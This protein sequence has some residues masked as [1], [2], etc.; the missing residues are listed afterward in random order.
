M[1]PT[2][3]RKRARLDPL[4]APKPDLKCQGA[5]DS[6]QNDSIFDTLAKHST[7]LAVKPSRPWPRNGSF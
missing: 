2:M 5:S 6:F 1:I 4:R 3:G 7:D